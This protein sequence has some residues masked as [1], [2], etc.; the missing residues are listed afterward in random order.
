MTHYNELF[1]VIVALLIVAGIC[2]GLL[3]ALAIFVLGRRSSSQLPITGTPTSI[4]RSKR[5]AN[6]TVMMSVGL[7]AI[8]FSANLVPIEKNSLF[9][10]ILLVGGLAV[11]ALS[12]FQF[13][14]IRILLLA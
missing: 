4:D 3:I 12:W 10:A 14:K 5:I 9:C 8:V 11:V 2:L 7:T 1:I 6:F 13:P